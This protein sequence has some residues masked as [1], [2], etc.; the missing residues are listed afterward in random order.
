[1]YVLLWV[2]LNRKIRKRPVTTEMRDASKSLAEQ[3]I[4]LFRQAPTVSMLPVVRV[5]DRSPENEIKVAEWLRKLSGADEG[6]PMTFE[7]AFTLLAALGVYAVFREFPSELQRHSYAFYCRIA[8]QR[9][10]FVNIDTN[11]LDLIFQIL[12]EIV[13]AVQDEDVPASY[14]EEEE[15]FCDEVAELAQFP[16]FYANLVAQVLADC[17]T[18]TDHVVNKLKEISR[19]YGHSLWGIYYRLK[20]LGKI[21]EGLNI[22]GAATN[23]TKSAPKVREYIFGNHDPRKYVENLYN[24]SPKFMELISA[25]VPGCSIRKLGEWLGLDTSVD[26]QAVMEEITRRKGNM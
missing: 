6:K 5:K 25:Q 19:T 18:R 21:G 1:M 12:H 24:L 11:I 13:H 7:N 10:V 17:G 15:K 9:V 8:G 22:A 2:P 20:H 4:N 23:L 3:Y 14:I 16:S 26:A